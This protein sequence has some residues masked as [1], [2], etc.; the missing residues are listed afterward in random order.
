VSDVVISDT[1]AND[2]DAELRAL[3]GAGDLEGVASRF[4]QRHGGEI[5][6][7][8]VV[9]LRDESTASEVFSEFAEDFWRGLAGFRWRTTLRSW[10]Y[11]LARNAANRFQ[12][13]RRRQAQLARLQPAAGRVQERRSSTAPYLRTEVKKR[14]RALRSQLPADDQ[15]LLILRIDKGLSWNEL[16]VIFSGEGDATTEAEKARWA[17]RL[18]QRFAAIKRRLRV[19]AEQEGLV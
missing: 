12:R 3:V 10:A 17:A 8:L 9:R 6:A 15:T 7:F 5:L 1:P 16:A 19:L 2:G 4:M 11:A 18:R 13:D 14:L